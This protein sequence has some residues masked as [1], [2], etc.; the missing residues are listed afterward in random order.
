M[1]VLFLECSRGACAGCREGFIPIAER[2][3]AEV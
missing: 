1:R 3:V 2:E